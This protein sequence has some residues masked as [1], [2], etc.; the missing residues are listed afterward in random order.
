MTQIKWYRDYSS[1]VTNL[2]SKGSPA[3]RGRDPGREVSFVCTPP[4]LR[5]MSREAKEAHACFFG[6]A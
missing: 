6:S 2:M 4:A 5:L 1:S 3:G